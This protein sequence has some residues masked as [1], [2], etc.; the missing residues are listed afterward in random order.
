[1][2]H[3]GQSMLTEKLLEQIK[4]IPV[5]DTHEHMVYESIFLKNKYDFTHLMSYVGLDLGLAGFP[6]NFWHTGQSAVRE[7][8][9]VAA[10]WKGIEPYWDFVRTGVYG[11]AYR[12]LLKLFFDIDDLNDTSV[13]EISER[14]QDYQFAGVYDKIL[15]QQFGIEVMLRVTDETACF[16]PRHFANVCYL[17]N[18]LDVYSGAQAE[19]GMG[20]ALPPDFESFRALLEQKLTQ[21]ISNGAVALKIGMLARQRPLNFCAHCQNEI[22]TSYQFLRE[23]AGGEWLDE[24]TRLRLKA[25]QD[26]AYWKAFEFA[27]EHDLPV[28]IHSGL[29]F[30]QPWDGRPAALIPSIIRFPRTKFVIFH[31]SYPHIAELTGLAKSFPNVYLDLAWLHLLS[32]RQT[33]IWMSEWLD[34]LPHNKIFAFGGDVFL[35]FGICSHL[36]LARENIAVVL[37]ERINAGVCNFDEAIICAKRLFYDNPRNTFAFGNTNLKAKST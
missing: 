13:H 9:S 18:Y 30:P 31:G 32:R 34:V 15:H 19:S 2:L 3:T 29:E 26:A 21:A 16:E 11:R 20:Q 35:F 23:K 7:G 8:A 12:R 10:K 28:Q 22:E 24:E 17:G 5:I 33:Q 27:A 36:E 14:I 6:C 1:M 4:T 37:G 25:F